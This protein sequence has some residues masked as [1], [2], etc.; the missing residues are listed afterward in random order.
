[1]TAHLAAEA[2]VGASSWPSLPFR[3]VADLVSERNDAGSEQMLS[4]S[5]SGRVFAR[6]GDGRQASSDATIR[7]GW[8]ARPGDLIVNPMWLLGGGLAVT[9][10]SGAV[11]PDYRVYRFRPRCHPRYMHHLLRSTEYLA[12][13]KLYGRAETTFDR[14]VSKDDFHSMPVLLP[15]TNEQK[16]IA[17]FLDDEVALLD[18]AADLRGQQARLSRERLAAAV[19]AAFASE[20][21][22]TKAAHVLRVQPGYAFPSSE[23]SQFSGPRLLRGTNVGVGRTDWSDAVHWAKHDSSIAARFSLESGDLV[24]GMDRPWISGGLRIA[25]LTEAD[26]PALLL[27]RVARLLTGPELEP[28]Y[29]FWA[30]QCRQFRDSVESELTGLSVPHLSSEQVAGHRFPVPSRQAQ[31]AI[32]AE[33][34]ALLAQVEHLGVLFRRSVDTLN[35]RKR[36]LTAAALTG[37]IDLATARSVA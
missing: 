6:D 7:A 12:Q 29:V 19:D 28:R 31:M 1:M 23:F 22:L 17:N 33:L 15:P 36:T 32:A 18:Q 25:Q 3:Q 8:V 9:S 34:D 10:L 4:V 20:R 21:A 5:S 11:S 30:Y 26:L 35:E 16:R 13:Y 37:E 2:L 24:M 27:Q 14:R